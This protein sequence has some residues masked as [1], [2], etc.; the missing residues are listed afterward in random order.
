MPTNNEGLSVAL[1]L[2]IDPTFGP[3]SLNTTFEDLAKQNLKMLLLTNKGERIMHP[4][5]GVGLRS[6]LF[7]QNSPVTFGVL[8]EL[9]RSQVSQYLPYIGINSI[10]FATSESVAD[11]DPNFMGITISFT[12]L[13]LQVSTFL[14]INAN[15]S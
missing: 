14:Q 8:D 11:L 1:P 9:I 6:Y 5:F 15:E 4:N 3:Y 7:E 13:P 10:N 12:I 2:T